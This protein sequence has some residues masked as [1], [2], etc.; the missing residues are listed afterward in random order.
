MFYTSM[1]TMV[2]SPAI[3]FVFIWRAYRPWAVCIGA[4]YFPIMLVLMY[5][6]S[7]G[8]AGQLSGVLP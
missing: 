5:L 6:F 3:G 8:V 1:A 2:I 4:V 7:I